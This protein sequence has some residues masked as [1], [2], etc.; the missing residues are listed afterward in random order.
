MSE[1]TTQCDW[2]HEEALG[3]GKIEINNGPL[4]MLINYC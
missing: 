2:R 4:E 1:K 3:T